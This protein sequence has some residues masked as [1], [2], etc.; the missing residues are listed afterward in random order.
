[1]VFLGSVE[2]Y[3]GSGDDFLTRDTQ[4]QRKGAVGLGSGRGRGTLRL[5]NGG[6]SVFNSSVD[7]LV[8]CGPGK[9]GLFFANKAYRETNIHATRSA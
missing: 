1:M 6:V 3:L 7:A 8:N 4:G 5:H 2:H 9:C